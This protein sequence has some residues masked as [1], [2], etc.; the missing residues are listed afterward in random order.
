MRR[1]KTSLADPALRIM[2]STGAYVANSTDRSIGAGRRITHKASSKANRLR[3]PRRRVKATGR[4]RLKREPR[5][6]LIAP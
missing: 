2:T 5:K 4:K 3:R 6:T 1:K